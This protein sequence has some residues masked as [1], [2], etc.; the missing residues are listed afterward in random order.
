MSGLDLFSFFEQRQ[1]QAFTES[2]AK[3]IFSQLVRALA[4]CH[5]RNV[6]HFD[7]KL[8]NIMIDPKTLDVKI[9]DFG[10]CDF[11]TPE[12]GGLFSKRVGSEEYCAPEIYDALNTPFDGT[13]VDAWCLGVVLYALLCASF[14]FDVVKRKKMIREDGVHPQ[15]KI[16]QAMSG[17]AKDLI[18]KLLEVNPEKRLSM[19]EVLAHSWVL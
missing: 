13:K 12:N 9:I 8:D 4:Y 7:I 11:I 1:F 5:S 14:P 19:E 2:E 15:V 17:A 10:L 6:V 16:A 3:K 18:E